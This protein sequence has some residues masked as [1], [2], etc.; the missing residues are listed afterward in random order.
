MKNKYL[1]EDEIQ[2]FMEK[3]KRV[4]EIIQKNYLDELD[5]K[6][7]QEYAP[8]HETF[9]EIVDLFGFNGM[10]KILSDEKYKKNTYPE[11]YRGVIDFDH[12]AELLCSKTYNHG[13]GY[14]NGIFASE[15][16][17]AAEFYTVPIEKNE[18]NDPNKVLSLKVDSDNGIYAS[19][20]HMIANNLSRGVL[21]F[22]DDDI[23]QKVGLLFYFG[24]S[25]A[26]NKLRNRFFMTLENDISKLAVILGYDYIRDT[27]DFLNYT[28][29]L[30]RAKISVSQ[31]EFNKFC[32]NSKNYKN[33]AVTSS[34]NQPNIE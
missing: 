12:T 9:K 30:N 6:Y 24:N 25:I 19:D 11:V 28:I 26:D 22:V 3:L 32:S 21:G 7:M 33:F 23:K 13:T 20:L 8:S 1:N 2:N 4:A 10:P 29:I 14:I 31:S 16:K 34:Q 15:F 27:K 17:D 18:E 5:H